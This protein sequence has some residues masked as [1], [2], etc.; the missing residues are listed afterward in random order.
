MYTSPKNITQDVDTQIPT[1]RIVTLFTFNFHLSEDLPFKYHSPIAPQYTAQQT[2]HVLHLRQYD[3][4]LPP[5]PF[6]HEL[7]DQLPRQ[8]KMPG[9]PKH[10]IQH[11]D[12][13]HPPKPIL[14]QRRAHFMLETK[15]FRPTWNLHISPKVERRPRW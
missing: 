15:R 8:L 9:L 2:S 11:G 4:L 13:V 5:M 7:G 3:Q 6:R 14:R 1:L 12:M 10:H